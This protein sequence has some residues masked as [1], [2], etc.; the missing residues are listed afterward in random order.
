MAES[1]PICA[2]DFQDEDMIQGAAQEHGEAGEDVAEA[3]QQEDAMEQAAV[4][5]HGDAVQEAGAAAANEPP[6]LV[7]VK[8]AWGTMWTC[9]CV[10]C[11]DGST[12]Y[13][14]FVPAEPHDEPRPHCLPSL[15]RRAPLA[16]PFRYAVEL[17]RIQATCLNGKISTDEGAALEQVFSPYRPVGSHG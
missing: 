11:I 5:E 9:S 8:V 17:K 3:Q 10:E 16:E 15:L 14:S 7:T 1:I 13:S 12:S 2:G 6:A 4:E